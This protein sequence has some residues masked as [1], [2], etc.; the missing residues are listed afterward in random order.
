MDNSICYGSPSL[1]EFLAAILGKSDP[2]DTAAFVATI[3][4]QRDPV[5]TGAFADT[6]REYSP[7]QPRDNWGRWTADGSKT[8][9]SSDDAT[10]GNEI[11]AN[12]STKAAKEVNKLIG[13]SEILRSKLKDIAK[14]TK[15]VERGGVVLKAVKGTTN[16]QYK[17]VEETSKQNTQTSCRIDTGETNSCRR[18]PRTTASTLMLWVAKRS[19]SLIKSLQHGIH[20]HPSRPATLI[21]RRRMLRHLRT[22]CLGLEYSSGPAAA[23]SRN[24]TT[25]G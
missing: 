16:P 17:F 25:C 13:D 10:D 1:D 3:L 4:G 22:T 18:C 20:T 12:D 14:N 15:T 23:R 11:D 19:T 21:L 2:A 6:L 24:V 5:I 7:D 8:S 9:I